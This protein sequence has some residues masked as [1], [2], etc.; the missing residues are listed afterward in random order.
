VSCRV[1]VG[2]ESGTT[3][4]P[5]TFDA[6]APLPVLSV[7][8]NTSLGWSTAATVHGT[9][10][11]P[12]QQLL[13]TQ[14]AHVA[15]RTE[16][17][18]VGVVNEP[19]VVADATGAFTVPTRIRRLMASSSYPDGRP[20]V[21]CAHVHCFLRAVPPPIN[22]EDRIYLYRSGAVDTALDIA[23]DG[24]PIALIRRVSVRNE[25][26]LVIN[27]NVDLMAPATSPLTITYSTGT[28]P[29]SIYPDATAGSDYVPKLDHHL[30]F[31]PGETHH[32]I[33][34]ALVDDNVREVIEQVA[35][36]LS[37]S[38]HANTRAAI[39]HIQSDDR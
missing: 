36:N 27:I 24:I 10:F 32:Q 35:V 13:L 18:C 34:I 22:R 6:S 1:S 26:R 7:T 12:D 15:G 39:A 9:G 21:D 8:P 4:I 30:Y 28:A 14:C 3:N 11:L 38:F 29:P 31:L 37:G 5:I 23:D 19:R 20:V 17:R 25:N 2:S 33:S 16:P